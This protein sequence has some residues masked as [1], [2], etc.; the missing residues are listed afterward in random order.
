[1][2]ATRRPARRSRST[3]GSGTRRTGRGGYR[4]YRR[5][6]SLATTIGGALGAVLVGAVL[7]LSWG[8]RIGIVL[9]VLA[10]GAAYLLITRGRAQPPPSSQPADSPADSPA[11][12]DLPTDGA[13]S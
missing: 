11:D 4:R 1:M 8:A 7:N 6:P 2:S 10:V 9:A 3:R 13:S 5:R 12:P